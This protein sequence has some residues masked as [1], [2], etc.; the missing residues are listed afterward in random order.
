[1]EKND[2]VVERL[3]GRGKSCVS[4]EKAEGKRESGRT[5]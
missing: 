3:A 1:M 4:R 5:K 2:L